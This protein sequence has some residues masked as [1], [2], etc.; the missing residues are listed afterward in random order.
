[1]YSVRS[2]ADAIYRDELDRL[3]AAVTWTLTRKQPSGWTG[4][5]GRVT[6]ALLGEV[7]WPPAEHPL[8]FVCGPT[9]FVETVASSLTGLGYPAD[10]VKTERF[11]GA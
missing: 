10:R 5:S 4:R 1:V 2:L 7:A 11:G 3:G 8:A 9:S 6:P